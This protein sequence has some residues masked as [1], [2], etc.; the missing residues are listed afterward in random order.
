[1]QTVSKRELILDAT[2][3]LLCE[4]PSQTISVSDIA[5]KAGIGKGS[6]YYYYKSKEDILQA[7]TERTYSYAISKGKA[8]VESSDMDVFMKM[9]II[10]QTCRETS[11]ELRRQESND[12]FEAQQSALL[13][14]KFTGVLI[15]N[16]KPILADIIRQGDADGVIH[17][18]LPEDVAE[19]VLIVLTIK[20]DN[21][22]LSATPEEL[23]RSLNAFA[24]ILETTMGIAHG[25]LDFLTD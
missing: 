3:Q 10:F 4:S 24:S 11:R 14:Q 25:K 22:I 17:C 8:L 15:K 23:Q 18:K 9:K 7:L 1:M 13:H 2:Q 6:I 20:L 19:L 16:L 5:K 21:Q 12:F